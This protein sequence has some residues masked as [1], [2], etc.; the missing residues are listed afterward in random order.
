MK[1]SVILAHPHPGSFNHA[2]AETAV[3]VLKKHGHTAVFHDLY[4]ERFDPVLPFDEIPR[5][6]N[7]DPDIAG[8]CAEIAEADG[9]IIVHPN[10][11]DQPPAILKGW[12]DRV[13]RPGVAYRFIEGD[14]GEGIPV[15]L[16]RARTALVFNTSNTPPEREQEVFGDS[17]ENLWKNCILAFCGVPEFHRRMFSVV[18]TSTEEERR[19]W[20]K[21][22]EKTIERIFPAGENRSR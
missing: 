2:I 22:V 13:L 16:L 8:H 6:G 19:E 18:V 12:V 7:L 20:L 14:M 5:D 3:A 10:W 4:A 17:L 21:E 9:I 11:W 1:I 15:G